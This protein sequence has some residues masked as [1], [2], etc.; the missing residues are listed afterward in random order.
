VGGTHVVEAGT[1]PRQVEQGS[2]AP[3][4][5]KARTER[6]VAVDPSTLLQRISIELARQCNLQCSYCYA[7]A[8]S[9]PREGLSDAEVR[10]VIAEAVALGARLVSFVGGGETLLRTSMLES[11]ESAI[12]Y[13][14]RLGCYCCLYTNCTLVDR[15]AARWLSARD[16]S[17][18]GKLNSLREDVQ[19]AL[20]GVAGSSRRIRRGIDALL[21]AGLAANAEHR[22]G[23]ESVICRQNYEEMPDLWRWM[24]SH[25]VIPEVEIPTLHGRAAEHRDLLYFDEQEAP[26][27]YRA[28]FE[29]LL[30]IDRTEF[31]FD[32]VPHPP[33]VAGSCRLYLSNCYVNDRGG[34]QPCAGVDHEY[35]VLRVGP[36]AD[37]GQPLGEI[38]ASKPFRELRRVGEL[39]QGACQSCELRAE[40]YGCRAAAWHKCGN[41]FGAD[42]VCWRGLGAG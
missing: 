29:E 32:W 20:T 14:N 9:A 11:G 30:R 23:L 28:L 40:C 3:P 17:V 26:Q 7:S 25:A 31:G 13:S 39:V 12:D 33:F 4:E 41:V 16:V 24:R 36:R 5:L 38:L 10:A 2:A 15:E 27:K 35:G 21:E 18:V 6:T 8:S 37:A 22:L 19:D 42:P 34:V 1:G